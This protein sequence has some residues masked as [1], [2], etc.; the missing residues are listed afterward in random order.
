M[1]K[2]KHL[3]ELFRHAKEQN[4][5]VTFS[6]T[7]EH[8]LT[9]IASNSIKS[10]GK[11]VSILLTKKLILMIVAVSTLIVALFFSN[12]QINNRSTSKFSSNVP[13][14]KKKNSV[15]IENSEGQ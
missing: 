6:R 11:K 9:A 5:V 15:I 1:D 13:I 8:F 2:Q 4:P 10:K 12:S 7:K 14:E 3:D